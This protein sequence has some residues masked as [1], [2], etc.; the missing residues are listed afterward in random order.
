MFYP[1]YIELSRSALERNLQFIR[2]QIG[3][4][5]LFS[6]VIKGN[7]YGHGISTF[8]PLAEKC[9]V[10]HFSV[11][12]ANEAY[13]TYKSSLENSDIMI[14]G[15]ADNDALAW[16][17]KHDIAFYVYDL[18]RLN[19]AVKFA[20]KLRKPARIHLELETGLNRTGL[21]GK[22]LSEA[23]SRIRANADDIKIEGVCTH[24]AGAESVGNYYRIQNQIWAYH[25]QCAWLR[26]QGLNLGLRHTASSAGVFTYP[27]TR[28]EM[29]RVG[30][31]QYGFWPSKETEMHYHLANGSA[32]GPKRP[33]PL[34]RIMN[35]KSR[36]M[37]LKDVKPGQFVGY[38]T[39]YITTR[40]QKIAIVPVGYFHGFPRVL[41]NIG[42]VLLH[43]RRAN[44]IGLVHMNMLLLDVT[45]FPGVK[46]GD[47]VV[48]F[49]KQKKGHITVASFSDMTRYLN[50]EVLVRLPAEIPRRVVP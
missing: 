19:S 41:S 30:I 15:A 3:P 16:A 6:S 38:G 26:S 27:E 11:F 13:R 12:S 10:R 8:V 18:D 21:E 23:V 25:E 35:F 7:A 32:R 2:D 50:Y 29:V 4:N 5:V 48:I 39:S 46:K 36:I 34:R 44:V 17:V 28:M 42:H 24:Y 43:G 1:S 40:D 22:T 33:N 37:S 49:G 20:K 14:M 47:E 45:E 31:A 9:G